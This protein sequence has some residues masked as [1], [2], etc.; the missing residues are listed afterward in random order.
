L[1]FS[2]ILEEEADKSKYKVRI[3]DHINNMVVN[4]STNATLGL[5]LTSD[6]G[7]VGVTN[8][9][10]NDP[11]KPEDDLPVINTMTPLST[12]LF[13]S[14]VEPENIANKLKLEIF[15]TEAN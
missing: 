15:Y 2:G 7:F 14:N 11:E 13:G 8:A 6:I 5:V 3:T 9:M 12:I 4:D 1:N 10:L